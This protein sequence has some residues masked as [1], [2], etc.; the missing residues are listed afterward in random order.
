MKNDVSEFKCPLCHSSL[1]SKDY[2]QAIEDLKRK[3]LE[4]YGE[5]NK[6]A[7][8][9]YEQK[10]QEATKTHKEELDNLKQKL[11]REETD[12][13]GE[14][15]ELKRT[16]VS[17]NQVIQ[18]EKEESHKQQL[19]DL[20]KFYEL[21]NKENQKNFKEL[22][23]QIKSQ[24]KKS[25]NEKDH[26]LLELKKEQDRLE[27]IAFDKGKANAETELTKLKNDIEEQNI[28]IER[29]RQDTDQLK[30]QLEQRQ[31]ELT[32]ERGERNLYFNLT[33][34]FQNDC[35]RPQTRGKSM[36]DIVH[37]IKTTTNVLLEMPIVYDNKE[38]ASVTAKDIE[39]AKKYKEIHATNYVIIVSRN[40]PKKIVKN[41]LFG[42]SDGILLCHPCIVV[43]VVR[44]IRKGMIEINKQSESRKDRD[45]KESKLY[46]YIRGSDFVSTL[47]KLHTIYQKTA[48]LQDNEEKAHAT[49][50]KNRKNLQS[51]IN[52]VYVDISSGVDSIIQEKVPMQEIANEEKQSEDAQE[53][54]V[55]P[56]SLRKNKR[57]KTIMS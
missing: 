32:G 9:E 28:Q 31:A 34:A 27:K 8:Q 23:E 48:D 40:L 43:D 57:K 13:K 44:Q 42:E 14:I 12:H 30:K 46:D 29:F 7:K 56:M 1:E 20:K 54:I 21:L 4:T 18:R 15:T 3:V 22:E 51:Q 55:Q 25:I 53:V 26:Q 2:Y 17:E 52:D 37:Q 33:Q 47:E 16:L 38:A 39:K 11:Q 6:K 45:N 49:L 36:G 19:T 5:E 24:Y 41:G 10:I 50:W 35:L